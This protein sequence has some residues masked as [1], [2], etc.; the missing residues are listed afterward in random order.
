MLALLPD[1]PDKNPPG[2][3]TE[4]AAFSRNTSMANDDITESAAIPASTTLNPT[5]PTCGSP[6]S[7]IRELPELKDVM[8]QVG[9]E[10]GG[11]VMVIF[12]DG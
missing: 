9:P 1:F 12:G 11:K 8:V 4:S 6:V 10:K 7:P 2:V 5:V 3:E